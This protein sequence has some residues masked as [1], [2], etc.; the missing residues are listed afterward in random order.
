M[1]GLTLQ[2]ARHKRPREALTHPRSLSQIEVATGA[3]GDRAQP[4]KFLLIHV[5]KLVPRD[6]AGITHTTEDHKR[7]YL[8]QARKALCLG[9]DVDTLL[10][11]LTDRIKRHQELGRHS[12]AP[13]FHALGGR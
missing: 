5:T 6:A 1:Q 13:R 11:F 7:T 4:I 3:P 10:I 9:A 2:S 8:E 12:V